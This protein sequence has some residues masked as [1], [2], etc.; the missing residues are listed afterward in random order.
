MTTAF[1]V[2]LCSLVVL[3]LK[4]IVVS[5][6]TAEALGGFDDLLKRRVHRAAALLPPD[7]GDELEDEWLEE[8]AALGAR[9]LRALLFTRGLAR[10]AVAIAVS[11]PALG[12]QHNDE[13]RTET[14]AADEAA[15][16]LDE[17]VR[18]AVASGE[19]EPSPVLG[20]AA[21]P[22]EARWAAAVPTQSRGLTTKD[23]ARIF[24]AL[25]VEPKP[26]THH[27]AGWLVVDG[28]RVLP[29]HYS[30]SSKPMPNHASERF[31]KSLH[32]SRSE[33]A[34]L[35]QGRMTRDEYVELLRERRIIA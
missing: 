10:A 23:V 24:A 21:D 20:R 3:L 9:R 33:F 31:R 2:I 29:L 15:P 27:V 1:V 6:I 5:L 22:V 12:N 25:K 34:A 11:Q 18:A 4:S 19:P 35:R 32:L 8:L 30:R 26:S 16:T 7:S 28:R 17:P 14:L 13:S